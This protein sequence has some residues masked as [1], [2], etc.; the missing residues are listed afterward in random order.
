MATAVRAFSSLRAWQV[1]LLHSSQVLHA[2][3][4]LEVKTSVTL[5]A[6]GEL[7]LRAEAGGVCEEA[8]AI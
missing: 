2:L 7:V 5:C 1:L 8:A 6:G 4:L 3:T